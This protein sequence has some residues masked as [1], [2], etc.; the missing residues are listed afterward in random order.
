MPAFNSS[1]G[2]SQEIEK[3]R[4]IL[5]QTLRYLGDVETRAQSLSDEVYRL[6]HALKLSKGRE[7][8]LKA[9]LAK[10]PFD[11]AA[12]LRTVLKRSRRQKTMINRLCKENTRLCKALKTARVGRQAAEVRVAGLRTARR[13]LS[14]SLSGTDAELRRSLRRSRRQKATIKSLSRKSTRLRKAVKAARAGRQ[15]A[16]ARVAGLRTAR[17]TL[18]ASLSG[19][20]AELRRSLRRSR[21]QKATIKSLSRKNA[22]LR[23]AVKGSRGRIETLEAQLGKLRAS[24]SVMSKRLYGRKSEQQKKPGTGRKRGQQ[25]GAP[26]HGRT[27]RPK[28]EERPEEI[29]PPPE[30]CA[31]ARCG[32]AYVPN[33]TEDSTLVEIEVKAHK[34]VISRPR[35]RRTCECASSPIEV[36]APPVP[37]LFANT[38]YGISV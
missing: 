17:R 23:K 9:R 1:P 15:A 14:T 24:G 30:E 3:Q 29:N 19:T 12:Q 28:L 11:E 18:S 35:F 7:E 38:L 27:Q 22:G 36:S 20:D 32:Q 8:K 31:C 16:E 6:H 34:R 5:G 33:G 4:F 13:T 10:L 2:D 26:G 25:R 21:R 37:R